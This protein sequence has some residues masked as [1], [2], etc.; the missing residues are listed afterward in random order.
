M[1]QVKVFHC[2]S[3][4]DAQ[5]VAVAVRERRTVV[6][7][8]QSLSVQV[9]LEFQQQG[10]ITVLVNSREGMGHGAP[11]TCHC[12]EQL[13]LLLMQQAPTTQVVYRSD[14]DGPIR[15]ADVLTAG[16]ALRG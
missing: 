16:L 14:R 9:L 6:L 2:R 10:T 13:L 8:P 12:F 4:D 3:F 7:P 15:Q 5:S 11:Q 1:H